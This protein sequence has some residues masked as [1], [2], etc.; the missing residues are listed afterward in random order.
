M[1]DNADTPS[2]QARLAFLG[3]MEFDNASA[4]RGAILV[5][6]EWGKPLEFRCTAPVKPNAVQRTLYGQ[7]LMPHILVELIGLPLLQAVQE[8]P[9]VVIIREDLFFDL[10]RKADTPVVRVRRQ[11]SDVKVQGDDEADK[12]KAVVI[13]SESERFETIVMEPHWQF[14]GDTD[15]CQERIRELFARWDL[16]EPFDRVSKGLEYVH[17]QKVL[18]S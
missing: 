12:P 8:K 4:Y 10:R 11:G 17:Q 3:Y 7:T 6:D 1:S 5:T 15:F 14:A 16:L 2:Q 13:A 18:A 9:E